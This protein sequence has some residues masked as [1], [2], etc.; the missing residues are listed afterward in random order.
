MDKEAKSQGF[1][2]MRLLEK[3]GGRDKMV[4]MKKGVG[5]VQ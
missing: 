3:G 4:L 2:M 1:F 5:F